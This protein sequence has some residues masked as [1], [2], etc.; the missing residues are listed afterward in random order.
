MTFKS[1]LPKAHD[2]V[3]AEVSSAG[4]WALRLA[5]LFMGVVV[6]MVVVAT[7]LPTLQLMN[8][9]SRPSGRVFAALFYSRL[10]TCHC[11]DVLARS[12]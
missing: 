12:D 6:G 7:S 9:I 8:K 2:L 1:A 5:L 10:P 3:D 4:T 11:L